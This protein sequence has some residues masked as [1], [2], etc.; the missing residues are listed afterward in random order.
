MTMSR[1]RNLS[2]YTVY[3]NNIIY[4]TVFGTKNIKVGILSKDVFR[5]IS[6][7]GGVT[8]IISTYLYYFIMFS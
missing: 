6:L 5:D 8:G 4:M 3:S 7:R 1:T 2:T